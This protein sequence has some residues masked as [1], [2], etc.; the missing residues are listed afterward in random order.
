LR[1]LRFTHSL[2]DEE[3]LD[4]ADEVDQ[5]YYG[6]RRKEIARSIMQY[7]E[8]AGSH[9]ELMAFS[10]SGRL[11]AA[12]ADYNGHFWPHYYYVRGTSTVRYQGRDR[13]KIDAVPVPLKELTDYVQAPEILPE[14]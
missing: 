6:C 10:P 11:Y 5:A 7:L 1:N 13:T 14:R 4:Q 12:D 8:D 2:A 9:I 3:D